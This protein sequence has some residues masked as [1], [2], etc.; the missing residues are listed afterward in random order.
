MIGARNRGAKKRLLCNECRQEKELLCLQR[1]WA[2]GPLLQK[3]GTERQNSKGEKVRIQRRKNQGKS[4]IFEQLKRGRKSRVLQLGSYN[5]FNVLAMEI[6]VNTLKSEESKCCSNYQLFQPIICL[7]QQSSYK[8]IQQW[9][10]QENPTR[11]SHCIATLYIVLY[12]DLCYNNVL[13]HL[14]P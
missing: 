10:L 9:G 12:H 3:S 1:F 2:H 5:K 11:S 7:L 13:L 14:L 8:A 4:G 6:N